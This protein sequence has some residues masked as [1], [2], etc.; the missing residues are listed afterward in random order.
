MASMPLQLPGLPP[1][2]EGWGPGSPA[3]QLARDT[4]LLPLGSLGLGFEENKDGQTCRDSA[5]PPPRPPSR[6]P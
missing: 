5:P 4:P 6:K 3:V 1:R 2:W